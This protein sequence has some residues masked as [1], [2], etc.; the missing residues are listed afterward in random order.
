M[1]SASSF[2]ATGVPPQSFA[3][4]WTRKPLTKRLRDWLVPLGEGIVR[5][6][7][8]SNFPILQGKGWRVG[9]TPRQ[10]RI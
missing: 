3:A 5:D 9:V 6:R 1:P 10:S 7:V 4:K 2:G 8:L